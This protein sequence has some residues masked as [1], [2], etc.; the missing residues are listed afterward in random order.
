METVIRTSA[1]DSSSWTYVVIMSWNSHIPKSDAATPRTAEEII[2]VIGEVT[3]IDRR[4][5][6]LIRKPRTPYT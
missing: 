5:A 4:L 3:L 1:D 2:W 6:M